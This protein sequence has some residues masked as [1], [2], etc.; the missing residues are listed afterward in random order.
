MDVVSRVLDLLTFYKLAVLDIH[1]AVELTAQNRRDEAARAIDWLVEEAEEVCLP[2]E[3]LADV[4]KL[5]DRM[6]RAISAGEDITA[7]AGEFDG[8]ITGIVQRLIHQAHGYKF[9]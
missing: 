5:A 3:D 9:P 2:P 7:I 4:K 1:L 6:K 8:T